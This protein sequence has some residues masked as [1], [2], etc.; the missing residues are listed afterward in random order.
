M[1]TNRLRSAFFSLA[2]FLFALSGRAA[3][4]V[5]INS[6]NWGDPTIWK[7]GTVPG[8]NDD[9]DI[10]A[11]Y[12]VTVDT[13]A[14]VQYIYGSGTLTMG[15]NSTLNVVSDPAGA[16]G[17]TGITGAFDTSAPGNTV[18]YSGNAFWCKHQNYYNL[19]MSGTNTPNNFYNGN[20]GSDSAVAMT[21]AGDMTISGT[22]AV[23]AGDDITVNGN[24]SIGNGCIWDCSSFY[25]TVGGN[26]TVGGIL[27]DLD[28]ALGSNH[29]GGNITINPG[30]QWN[31]TDVVHWFAG[32]SVTNNGIMRGVGYGSI[33]FGGTGAIS[34]K[35]F[36]I[37]TMVID[38]TYTIGTAIT[39][40]TNTPT[41]NGTVIFDIAQTNQILLTAG[42][43]WIWYGGNL[44]VINSGAAPTA[45]RTY[46]FFNAP[47]YGGGFA[48]TSF[49][50]LSGGLS[51]EDD[52]ATSGS[53]TVTSGTTAHP[54][55][56]VLKNGNQLTLFWDSTTFPGFSV[57]ALTNSSGL[58]GGTWSATGSGTNSPF[59]TSVNPNNPAVFFRL[60]N[61]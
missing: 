57:K 9:A 29:F 59:Q 12:N 21:I 45:G 23:Q 27:Y 50:T 10:E 40:K 3:D 17:T 53:I 58:G 25:I 14:S 34:G 61:Q 55:L 11:P 38:G 28:G 33:T 47:G 31:I 1:K 13:N 41:L 49:P 24:L 54:T 42:T 4:I 20:T 15:P 26:T 6:G 32:G 7:T 48:T 5:A 22:V 18:I 52:L 51:W 16:N 39:L 60:S 37:P 36:T 2:L 46:K 19:V 43:N 35:P 44:N 8:T 30:G 56:Y